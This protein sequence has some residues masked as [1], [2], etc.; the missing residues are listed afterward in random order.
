[1]PSPDARFPTELNGDGFRLVL[2]RPSLEIP[3]GSFIGFREGVWLDAATKRDTRVFDAGLQSELDRGPHMQS[4]DAV[5]PALD[6][7]GARYI[8]VSDRGAIVGLLRVRLVDEHRAVYA[9]V[10]YRRGE[11]RQVVSPDDALKRLLAWLREIGIWEVT[12]GDIKGPKFAEHVRRCGFS[13]V[14]GAWSYSLI[15]TR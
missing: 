5:Q 9:N 15:A 3:F 12:T 11:H 13:Q 1:M 6:E 8:V 10:L 2:V 14:D 4:W 7:L